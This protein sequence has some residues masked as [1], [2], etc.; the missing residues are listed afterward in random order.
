M[1]MV[2]AAQ[3]GFDAKSAYAQEIEALSVT[4]HEPELDNVVISLSITINIM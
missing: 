2:G 3:P 1:G 4:K